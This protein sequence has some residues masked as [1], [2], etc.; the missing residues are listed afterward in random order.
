MLLLC[1][2]FGL[3]FFLRIVIL[4]TRESFEWLVIGWLLLLFNWTLFVVIVDNLAVSEELIVVGLFLEEFLDDS[5]LVPVDRGKGLAIGQRG[6]HLH[7]MLNNN[8][9]ILTHAVVPWT[10]V[11]LS[12]PFAH[13]F[14]QVFSVLHHFYV[15]RR[16]VLGDQLSCFRE[17]I[18]V[19][20]LPVRV[21]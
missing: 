2:F 15:G 9:T 18:Y 16:V 3:V 13:W 17:S 1:L 21:W 5:A 7:I 11:R 14:V 6:H 10:I 4:E 20:V 12:T 8:R 19:L